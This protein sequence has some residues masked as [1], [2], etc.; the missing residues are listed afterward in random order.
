M[1]KPPTQPFRTLPRG[2]CTLV[3]AARRAEAWAGEP[4]LHRRGSRGRARGR[5]RA[6]PRA[7]RRARRDR[8]PG[9]GPSPQWKVAL[10]ADARAR[11]GAQRPPPQLASGTELRRHQIDALAGMLTELIA[12][13]QRAADENGERE[14]RTP[15]EP[16]RTDDE[17]EDEDDARARPTTRSSRSPRSRR[18]DPG[19]VRRYRFRHPT[20]SGQDDRR[21]RLRRGR[22]HARRPDPHPP[23]AAR[24]AVQPR[25]DGRGLRRPVRRRRSRRA[26]SRCAATR[27]RSRP[28]PGSR[29]T[30]ATSAAT[31][32]SS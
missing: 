6:P 12:A 30:S 9:R 8:A 29:A 20:A 28:T 15:S 32:T 26:R 24:L 5:H 1:Q 7:R 18:E 2:D 25:A 27:S 10:R 11:A 23:P 21:R 19:A 3:A 17:L 4:F 13:N 16:R 14:R 22:P 31:R